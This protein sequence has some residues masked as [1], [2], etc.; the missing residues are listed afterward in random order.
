[1]ESLP[2]SIRR[3]NK[4]I[5][6]TPLRGPE[7]VP[8]LKVGFRSKPIPIYEAARLMRRPLGGNH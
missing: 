6:P 2:A 4:R 8:F 7:I 3:P 5:Q 1:M